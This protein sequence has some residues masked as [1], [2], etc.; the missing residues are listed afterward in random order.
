LSLDNID[1]NNQGLKFLLYSVFEEVCA[2]RVLLGHAIDTFSQ[3]QKIYNH[4]IPQVNVA[5]IIDD[6]KRFIEM[7]EAPADKLDEETSDLSSAEISEV[8]TDGEETVQQDDI[9]AALLDLIAS[10]QS[11]EGANDDAGVT[12]EDEEDGEVDDEL[13]DVAGNET[14]EVHL[15]SRAR[16][17]YGINVPVHGFD[18]DEYLSQH[19]DD[20]HQ[21]S[22]DSIES[23]LHLDTL[24]ISLIYEG[25][26]LLDQVAYDDMPVVSS[27]VSESYRDLLHSSDDEVAVVWYHDNVNYVNVKWYNIEKFDIGKLRIY[28]SIRVGA[29]GEIGVFSHIL[30]D[31]EEPDEY[32]I[33]SV[34]KSGYTGPDLFYP[35]N[36]DV[37]DVELDIELDDDTE[38]E[39]EPEPEPEPPAA[40]A[41]PRFSSGSQSFTSGD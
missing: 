20:Y 33:D 35:D 40:K 36:Y 9:E 6:M 25:S 29:S 15:S 1:S 3:S 22:S 10:L 18:G 5:A 17:V 14:L 21:L 24:R 30:Y 38:P 23:E 16:D 4:T 41:R 12:D 11:R 34:P 26:T 8:V 31:S 39:S 37:D 13:S 7:L 2:D 28:S 32:E 19:E 27:G